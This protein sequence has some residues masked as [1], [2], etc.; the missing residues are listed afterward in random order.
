LDL[1]KRDCDQAGKRVQDA[2]AEIQEAREDLETTE[3]AVVV[4]TE[5]HQ[6]A[7]DAF[8]KVN[9]SLGVKPTPI[10]QPV[11]DASSFA[12]VTSFCR[13][14]AALNP[15]AADICNEMSAMCVKFSDMV[16]EFEKAQAAKEASEGEKSP[17]EAPAPGG[18]QSIV[19]PEAAISAENDD[20]DI[21]DLDAGDGQKNILAAQAALASGTGGD[22]SEDNRRQLK[23]QCT[24]AEKA[25][26]SALAAAGITLVG[27]TPPS[28]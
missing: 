23:K 2:L 26:K 25:A 17:A 8:Q 19:I 4:A 18:P 20:E 1:A 6:K 10:I 9:S 5:A 22:D 27:A 24:D 16:N 14:F 11:A 12:Q 28:G 15:L 13:A 21:S 7:W 3:K